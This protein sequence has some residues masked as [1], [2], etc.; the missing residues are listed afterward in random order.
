M[1]TS[2]W[3]YLTH[4]C[5]QNLRLLIKVCSML[6]IPLAQEKFESPFTIDM[7]LTKVRPGHTTLAVCYSSPTKEKISLLVALFL[8]NHSWIVAWILVSFSAGRL[9]SMC[10]MSRRIPEILGEERVQPREKSS[11]WWGYCSIL[12]KVVCLGRTFASCMYSVAASIQELDHFT[13]PNKEFRSDTYMYWW[14]T[15][16]R[17]WSCISFLPLR[18]TP[19]FV[20]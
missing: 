19:Q 14:H 6:G 17:E 12:P 18:S 1:I 20:T 7:W 15:S 2:Q 9:A 4:V 11:P 5:H 3:S 13:H 8:L 10:T 16:L